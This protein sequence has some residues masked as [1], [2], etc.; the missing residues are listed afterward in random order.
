MQ[1]DVEQFLQLRQGRKKSLR[2]CG[3]WARFQTERHLIMRPLQLITGNVLRKAAVHQ[4]S[5]QLLAY[6]DNIDI[7]II[8][9]KREVTAA[10]SAIEREF[11]KIGMAVNKSKIKYMLPASRGVQGSIDSRFTAD[12]YTFYTVKEFIYLGSAV[13]TNSDVS[14]EIKRRITLAKS[15]CY[16]LNGQLSNRGLSRTMKLILYK[17]ETIPVLLYGAEAWILL[18]TELAMISA[19]VIIASCRSTLTTWTL[20]RILIFSG[21]AGS[22]MPLVCRRML[23]RDGYLMRGSAVVG[24]EDNL[25]SVGRTK[26]RKPC[27]QFS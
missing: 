7:D 17:T 22:A 18:S 2:N 21:C 12:N 8:S 23:R 4:K 16:G 6:D 26:S 14:L 24:G 1:N 15:F 3:Y 10:F 9:T 11:T 19:S 5:V 20:C 25:V 13:T 27:H